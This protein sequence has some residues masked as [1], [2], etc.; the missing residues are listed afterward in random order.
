MEEVRLLCADI[1]GPETVIYRKAQSGPPVSPPVG[2]RIRGDDY[3][4]LID[5]AAQLRERLAAYPEL[6]NIVDTLQT[7]TPEL[8]ILINEERAAAY[9]LSA[10]AAGSFIRG[11]YDGFPA[12]TVFFGNEEL[13]IV[14][15]YAGTG[16]ANSIGRLLEL[17][18]PTP[19]GRLVPFSAIAELEEGAA[20][21]SIK[22]VDSKREVGVN[23]DAYVKDNVQTINQD[24]KL[25]FDTE[26]QA[27]YPGLELVVGGE[28]AELA[29]LLIQILRVFLLGVF[30]IYAVLGAQFKSFTQPLLILLSVPM[31]FA[32]VILYLVLSGTPFSTTVLYAGVALAGI[33]VNDA[34]VLID[35]INTARKEG[36]SVGDAVVEAVGVR[37]RPILLTSVT[38]I[39]GLLPTAIGLG[40]YS[41]VW[42]PMASTII[43]GLLFS[44]LTALTVVPALYGLLYDRKVRPARKELAA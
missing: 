28:F 31:A 40:G 38:T 37:L 12:G 19:D 43:F 24:I 18:I 5:T 2:F 16:G 27:R 34:I 17:K 32:G 22:R 6:I 30:L 15:R 23:A 3:E 7:G 14:V 9:G 44:T 36:K 41:V 29:D 1:P 42:S 21:A 11:S 8:R 39:G 10:A 26:V 25:W 33:A 13:D 35:F 4:A 20:L